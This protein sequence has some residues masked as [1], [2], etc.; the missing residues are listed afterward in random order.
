MD[1][2]EIRS[3]RFL[4]RATPVATASAQPLSQPAAF[5]ETA[6]GSALRLW[7]PSSAAGQKSDGKG[8]PLSLTE[9]NAVCLAR[10]SRPEPMWAPLLEGVARLSQSVPAVLCSHCPW[11]AIAA[12]VILTFCGGVFTGAAL[13]LVLVSTNCRRFLWCGLCG[14]FGGGFPGFPAQATAR[15]RLQQYLD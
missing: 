12:L 2:V 9:V 4:A 8:W 13:T 6:S 15:R 10:E 5:R 11:G 7:R 14:A 1:G 3:L